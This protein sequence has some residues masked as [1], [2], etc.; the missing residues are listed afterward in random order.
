MIDD[1]IR[2][3]NG[4]PSDHSLATLE[5]DIWAGLDR[6]HQSG[7]LTRRRISMQSV[8]M[9]LSLIVSMGVGIY[10]SRAAAVTRSRAVLA[11]GLELAPSSL[12]LGNAR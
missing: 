7:A 2:R 5:S 12:L 6:R 11:L 3:L 4:Q 8:V 9:A 10:S 1:D